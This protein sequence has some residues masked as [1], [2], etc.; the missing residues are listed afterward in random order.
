MISEDFTVDDL[1]FQTRPNVIIFLLFR[2]TVIE[3]VYNKLN[4]YRSEDTVSIQ[5]FC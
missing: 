5:T 4:P 1:K 3:A 2:R